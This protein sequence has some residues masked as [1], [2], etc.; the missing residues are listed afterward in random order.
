MTFTSEQ[1]DQREKAPK[2]PDGPQERRR[3]YEQLKTSAAALRSRIRSA[4]SSIR[5]TPPPSRCSDSPNTLIPY[6]AYFSKFSS[7]SPG[8][9]RPS[10]RA[11]DAHQYQIEAS[12][13][14]ES[15]AM[16]AL[17]LDCEMKLKESQ[18]EMDKIR[19][20]L[21]DKT[22]RT[23]VVVRELERQRR[24]L[25]AKISFFSEQSKLLE[26]QLSEQAIRHAQGSNL[27]LAVAAL[28]S[29][30]SCFRSEIAAT[31]DDI[32]DD[33]D[34]KV[35]ARTSSSSTEDK[36][37]ATTTFN[38]LQLQ[39]E[40][41]TE[42]KE[43]ELSKVASSYEDSVE[44]LRKTNEAQ[45]EE[46]E[47]LEREYSFRLEQMERSKVKADDQMKY[48]DVQMRLV[49]EQAEKFRIN[50]EEQVIVEFHIRH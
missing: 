2:L 40:A 39:R 35:P 36:E 19:E 28:W 22:R 10:S 37:A 25:E 38:E 3:R 20:R 43:Q 48:L 42:K 15:H 23:E 6:A 30:I 49:A 18:E 31:Q 50:Y 14:L 11:D 8:F 45:T 34:S 32:Q 21:Q 1:A 44:A 16:R 5:S 26:N 9:S 4:P 27:Q 41:F 46:I 17:R 7:P 33:G 24:K 29:G 12:S 13:L 47:K